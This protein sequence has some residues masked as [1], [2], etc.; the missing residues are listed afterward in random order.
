MVVA[1]MVED[2]AVED[3]MAVEC[4]EASRV[5]ARLR[6]SGGTEY[7]CTKCSSVRKDSPTK[8]YSRG[9]GGL[10]FPSAFHMLLDRLIVEDGC[11]R[12]TSRAHPRPQ[13]LYRLP[14]KADGRCLVR[15][16]LGGSNRHT[17]DLSYLR[18]M[19]VAAV[20]TLAERMSGSEELDNFV[21]WSFPDEAYD[22]FEAWCDAQVS[23]DTEQANSDL[24]KGGGTWIAYGLGLHLGLRI[25]VHNVDSNEVLDPSSDGTVLLDARGADTIA[26]DDATVHLASVRADDG[27][28]NHFDILLLNGPQPGAGLSV[29]VG[30]VCCVRRVAPRSLFSL[31]IPRVAKHERPP[32]CYIPWRASPHVGMATGTYDL[33]SSH[34]RVSCGGMAG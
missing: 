8:L 18:E 6:S 21:R 28:A 3:P 9:H 26:E 4:Q 16:V 2:V 22:S 14:V 25:I 11:M 31:W 7:D 23:D 19:R 20:H 27:T 30:E 24:W 13:Q 12:P 32:P 33:G 1:W 34:Q 5:S 17:D 10:L 29:A 15:A